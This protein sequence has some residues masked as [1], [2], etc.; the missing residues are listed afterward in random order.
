M[1]RKLPLHR[2]PKQK[3]SMTQMLRLG[4]PPSILGN[5]SGLQLC[6]S[7]MKVPCCKNKIKAEQGCGSGCR[8][9]TNPPT[10]TSATKT[11]HPSLSLSLSSDSSDCCLTNTTFL[12]ALPS[13]GWK[14]S[15]TCGLSPTPLHIQALSTITPTDHPTQL[16]NPNNFS[17]S[18]PPPPLLYPTLYD[19]VYEHQERT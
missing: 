11:R 10:W 3:Q 14:P 16:A 18:S 19:T 17:T 13:G 12:V 7:P 4:N 2:E 15:T 1:G 5:G 9:P 8:P 6:L